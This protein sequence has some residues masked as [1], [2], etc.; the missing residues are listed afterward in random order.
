MGVGRLRAVVG[1]GDVVGGQL[2]VMRGGEMI[3]D[4]AVGRRTVGGA[5][6]LPSDRVPWLCASK[7]LLGA[8]ALHLLAR[9]SMPLSTRVCEVIP[10]FGCH[11]KS[12]VEIGHLMNHTCGFRLAAHARD[13][14]WHDYEQMLEASI[15]A[16]SEPQ[17]RAGHDGGYHYATA[18]YVLSAVLESLGGRLY[19]EIVDDLVA[20]PFGLTEVVHGR[21]SG[22]VWSSPATVL[23]HRRLWDGQIRPLVYLQDGVLSDCPG[24]DVLGPISDLARLLDCLRQAACAPTPGQ[25]IEGLARMATTSSWKGWDRTLGTVME[26][27]FGIFLNMRRSGYG[28]ELPEAT[29]GH[30]GWDYAVG[31]AIP[32]LGLTM[33]V[34]VNVGSTVAAA[35]FQR[36]TVIAS[37]VDAVVSEARRGDV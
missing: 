33:S 14:A 7:V 5:P 12:Q 35:R 3:I 15:E 16:H 20:K 11:G 10:G 37:I 21:E 27:G 19:E 32:E 6:L 36:P 26:Y 2:A 28:R 22:P 29:F 17:W 30:P 34:F 18:S 4:E 1:D 13:Y 24:M 9:E 23:P 8:A 25:H 31:V